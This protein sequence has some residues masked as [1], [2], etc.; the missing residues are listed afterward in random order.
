MGM[1]VCKKVRLLE[2]DAK[3]FYKKEGQSVVVRERAIIDELSVKESE[4]NCYNNGIL[5][6]VD[7]KETKKRELLLNP[8][9]AE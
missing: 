1:K 2:K 5:W 6:V 8:K 3:G 9:T 7:E 4:G